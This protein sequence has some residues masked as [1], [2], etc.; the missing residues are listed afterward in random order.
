MSYKPVKIAFERQQQ[1]KI[2][3]EREQSVGKTEKSASASTSANSMNCKDIKAVRISKRGVPSEPESKT[4]GAVNKKCRTILDG[5]STTV[6][7]N[8][9]TDLTDSSGLRR[10]ARLSTKQ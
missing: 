5:K 3:R 8:H 2:A 9:K 4:L 1:L 7:S 6:R 10:S